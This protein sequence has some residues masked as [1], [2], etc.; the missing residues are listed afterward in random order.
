[1]DIEKR[2]CHII[3]I[4]PGDLTHYSFICLD[5]KDYVIIASS[6]RNPPFHT[7]EFRHDSI[8]EFFKDVGD[9]P[10]SKSLYRNWLDKAIDH[11]YI[12]YVY[13][14]TNKPNKCTC[15]AALIAAKIFIKLKN[16]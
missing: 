14:H 9:P 10:L 15:V 2:N 13:T 4:E 7:Y 1:M 12:D 6:I 11:P 5:K 3:T 8:A 16:S